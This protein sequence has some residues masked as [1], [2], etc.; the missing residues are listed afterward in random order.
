MTNKLTRAMCVNS[1][2]VSLGQGTAPMED[3]CQNRVA[4]LE[5]LELDCVSTR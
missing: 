2:S 5:G 4:E 3:S 1:L